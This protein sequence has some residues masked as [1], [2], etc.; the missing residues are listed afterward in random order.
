MRTAPARPLAPT[1][2]AAASRSV[3]ADDLQL[4]VPAIAGAHHSQQAPD[5]VRDP[6]VAT[7]DAAHVALVHG[8]DQRH[9]VVVLLDLDAN[10]VRV[11]DQRASHVIKELLHFAASA[12]VSAASASVSAASASGA[13]ASASGS[14]AGSAAACASSGASPGAS[15]GTSAG[16]SSGAST[17]ASAGTSS[18]AS[19]G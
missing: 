1:M 9:L 16:T 14:S 10:G 13:A 5:G 8:E 7:D 2:R 12:S 15:T 6:P 4:D 11:L 3:V 18:G 17:G 19:P